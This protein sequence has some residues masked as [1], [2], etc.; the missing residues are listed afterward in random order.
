M[1]VVYKKTFEVAYVEPEDE[2]EKREIKRII[3]EIETEKVDVN[4]VKWRIVD[5]RKDK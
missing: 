1:K 5:N 3:K 4:S 2:E